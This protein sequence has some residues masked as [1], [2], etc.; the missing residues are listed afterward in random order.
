MASI[1]QFKS[2]L[3]LP[4]NLPNGATTPTENTKKTGYQP[5]SSSVD[6]RTSNSGIQMEPVD[7]TTSMKRP[8]NSKKS[9][10]KLNAK[11]N[12]LQAS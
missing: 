12:L 4:L 8:L 5:I 7:L 3:P 10:L 9:N 6:L 1:Y 11:G 2:L